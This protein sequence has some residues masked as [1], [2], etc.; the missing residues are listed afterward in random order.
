MT[1]RMNHQIHF[2]NCHMRDMTVIMDEGNH[3]QSLCPGCDMF[4]L[5]KEL[6]GHP[7]TMSLCVRGDEMNHWRLAAEEA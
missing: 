6:N 3:P 1:I 5:W 7:P 4:V 2:V